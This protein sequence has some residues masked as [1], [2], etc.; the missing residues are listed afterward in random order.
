[1]Y[2]CMHAYVLS[3]AG[4]SHRLRALQVSPKAK[5]SFPCAACM[6]LLSIPQIQKQLTYSTVQ[7]SSNTAGNPS[8]HDQSL[9]A[10]AAT[11]AAAAALFT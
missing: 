6:C 11:A 3:C 7:Y 1:M 8:V 2:A 10:T 9:L 5:P 4:L